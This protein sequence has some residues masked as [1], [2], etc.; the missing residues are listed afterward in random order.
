VIWASGGSQ[1]RGTSDPGS[2]STRVHS[3]KEPFGAL[4]GPK[5]GSQM[6][7]VAEGVIDG[8]CSIHVSCAD[9]VFGQMEYSRRVQKGSLR[10][11]MGV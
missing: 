10:A 6:G 5:R 2:F 8:Y 1:I 9:R 7:W 4:L 11:Q 3:P